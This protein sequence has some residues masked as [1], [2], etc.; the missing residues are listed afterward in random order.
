MENIIGNNFREMADVLQRFID[1]DSNIGK[2]KDAASIMI[3]ALSH[4]NKI[5]SCGNGGSMCDASHFS[6]ELLARFRGDR[7]ALPAIAISDPAYITCVGNDYGFDQ[8]FSRYIEACGR[9]GDVLLGIS[10]SGN[11]EDVVKAVEMAR[12]KGMKVV[13]LTGKSNG[14][15]TAYCDVDIC[16]PP[17]KFSDR[18]QEIH[19][20]VIHTLV[21]LIERGMGLAG[22]D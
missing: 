14:K 17:T 4:G 15:L 16:T 3:E 7:I 9:K 18:A 2:I 21:Q 10:T 22:D 13:V 1:D 12:Q 11:S 6:E 5:I 20:K 8:I 19:I